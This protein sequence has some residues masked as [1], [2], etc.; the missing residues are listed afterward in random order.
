VA[1]VLT[2]KLKNPGDLTKKHLAEMLR[3]D[4]FS[5]VYTEADRVRRE[6]AGDIVHLRAIIEFSNVCGRKCSYCGLNAGNTGLDRFRMSS[7]EILSTAAKAVGAGY[8]TIVLQSGEDEY[9]TR[10]TL[11]DI[12][13][14][15]KKLKVGDTG[16]RINPS[17]TVSVGE[18]PDEDYR[19]WRYKGA[20]RYLLKHETADE[21]LYDK[22]HPCGGAA[23]NGRGGLAERIR[24]LKTLKSLGYEMGSGFMVGLPGL[25]EEELYEILVEDLLLLKAL[26]CEMAGIGP[27]IP[28]PKTPLE[29]RLRNKSS[30]QYPEMPAAQRAELTRRCVALARILLPKCN[31]PITTAL[32]VAE[33]QENPFAFGA[34]VIMNKVTPDEY[35]RAYE[36]YPANFPETDIAG[37]R[38]KIEEAICMYNRKPL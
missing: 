14:E 8:R 2:E 10:E 7:E 27:Y 30:Q 4:D 33:E 38:R 23:G 12:I 3:M 11:G 15:I 17:V 32:S 29:Q 20:D 26:D 5:E 24:C 35:K 18:R 25:R 31:L 28:N 22:L 36:I 1:A 37:D 21:T 13:A 16:E 6:N 19:Y 34:N 9:Y